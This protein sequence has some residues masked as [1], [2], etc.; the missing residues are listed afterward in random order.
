MK[1]LKKVL[2]AFLASAMIF[3]LAGCSEK[4]P[5]GKYIASYNDAKVETGVYAIHLLNN[6][7]IAA[8]KLEAK[9]EGFLKQELEGMTAKEWIV[10]QTK[11]NVN[12]ALAVNDEFLKRELEIKPE[13]QKYWEQIAQQ[14]WMFYGA[15]Y[16]K[17]G[18]TQEDMLALDLINHKASVVF[19][20]IYGK[21]GEKEV[22][23]EELQKYFDEN[24]E[25]FSFLPFFKHDVVGNELDEAGLK[26]KDALVKS[27]FAMLKN[28][29]SQKEIAT[30]YYDLQKADYDKAMAEEEEKAKLENE[31]NANEENSENLPNIPAVE[32]PEESL[33]E[34]SSEEAVSEEKGEEIKPED[35]EEEII[36]VDEERENADFTKAVLD[37]TNLPEGFTDEFMEMLVNAKIGEAILYENDQ[38]YI[39]AVKNEKNFEADITPNEE[40]QIIH[41]LKH[42]EYESFIHSKSEEITPKYD[43]ILVAEHSPAFLKLGLPSEEEEENDEEKAKEEAPENE[44][45]EEKP[46][47]EKAE[48]EVAEEKPQEEKAE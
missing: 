40:L 36:P 44:V 46:Q 33:E 10:D 3:A 45:T 11:K 5:K 20:D 32:L 16:A 23:S 7:M 37:R 2:C 31:Q 13:D 12:L 28:G 18:V 22:P 38:Y 19:A 15:G 9:D 43:D 48:N 25:S 27:Y 8:E 24:F 1:K 29:V 39:I 30:M 6:Y 35:A 4:E 34:G 26:E 42:E 47:E 17:S 14:Q 41:T 21:G